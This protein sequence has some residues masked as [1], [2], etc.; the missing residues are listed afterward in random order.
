MTQLALVSAQFVPLDSTTLT[1]EN[2]VKPEPL[3]QIVQPT[4][5]LVLVPLVIPDT[6]WPQAHLV[7]LSPQPRPTV[8]LTAEP[9]VLCA[10]LD[11]F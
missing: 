4:V 10:E 7:P 3:F 8:Q 6:I 9:N 11:T 2:S 5:L 1:S